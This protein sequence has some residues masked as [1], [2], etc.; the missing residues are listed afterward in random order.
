MRTLE[1]SGRILD[2]GEAIRVSVLIEKTRGKILLAMFTCPAHK[3]YFNRH[4]CTKCIKSELKKLMD[5][6]LMRRQGGVCG[7]RRVYDIHD[8]Q[9]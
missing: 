8:F 9:K 2:T 1:G 6:W 4:T 3:M 5:A 7:D